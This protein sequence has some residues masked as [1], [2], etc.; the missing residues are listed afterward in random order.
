MRRPFPRLLHPIV[1]APLAGGP[2]TPELAGAVSDAGGLG[3][4]AAGYKEPDAVRAEIA[5][6]GELTASPVGLNLFQLADVPVDRAGL[7]AYAKR[8]EPEARRYRSELGD[9]KFEDDRLEA[10]LEV[11]LDEP[12]PIVSFTFGCPSADIVQR[13]HDHDVA[14]WVTV[15]EVEEAVVAAHAGADAL[16]VQGVEAGGHRGSFDDADGRGEVGLLPL[17]RLVSRAVDIPL[18]AAGGIAD[19]AGVAAALVAGARAAQIGTG[20]LRC[21]EAATSPVHRAALAGPART[22]LTRAFTGRRARGI[23]NRFLLEHGAV[24]PSAYPHVHHLTAPLRSAARA[25]GDGEAINLW[26]GQAYPLAEELAAGDLVRRW[27]AEAAAALEDARLRL[28]RDRS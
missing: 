3:F 1:Q 27:S 16:V 5:R 18:V 4:L 23:V 19:G 7:S 14:V 17:L 26:A 2:S 13:L 21:P 24:A 15:T 28:L 6:T 22:V 9:P 12:V 11:V 20:F 10:K 8:L 25:A